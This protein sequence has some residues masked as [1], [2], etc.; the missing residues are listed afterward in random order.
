M[1]SVSSHNPLGKVFTDAELRSIGKLCISYNLILLSDEVYER[2]AFD[3]PFSRV[4]TLDHAIA[5]RTLTTV[6][7]GKLF[8]ATGWRVGFVI[9]PWE[10]IKHVQAVHLVLAYASSSPAQEALAVG[11]KEAEL[12]GFWGS[13]SQ[14]VKMKVRKICDVLDDLGLAVCSFLQIKLYNP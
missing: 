12:N 14:E 1:R 9:G 6:S 10:L 4:A 3:S 13:N 5:A 11:L 7:L 8:N 2:I